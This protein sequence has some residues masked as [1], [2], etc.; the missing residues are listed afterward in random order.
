MPRRLDPGGAPMKVVVAPKR[1]RPERPVLV[2]TRPVLRPRIVRQL[3]RLRP[4]VA[5]PADAGLEPLADAARAAAM[6][7]RTAAGATGSGT[8][9]AAGK[10]V[11]RGPGR[12]PRR[13]LGKA[14]LHRRKP[15]PHLPRS[16]EPVPE[17][18]F[19]AFAGAGLCP[20][21]ALKPRRPESRNLGASSSGAS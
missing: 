14:A 6:R 21:S 2:V 18:G 13:R 11:A 4:R 1:V 12:Q 8:V 7:E 5:E 17:I 3:E 10:E 19:C 9:V 20:T 16:K 15:C